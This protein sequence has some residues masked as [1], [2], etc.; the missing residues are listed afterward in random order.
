MLTAKGD[1]MPRRRFGLP[2]RRLGKIT[3]A[4]TSPPPQNKTRR[5]IAGDVPIA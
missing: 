3:P 2:G 5:A 4:S 1:E